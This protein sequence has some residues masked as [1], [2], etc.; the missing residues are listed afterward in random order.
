MAYTKLRDLIQ[1]AQDLQATS[2]GLTYEEM[3]EKLG[4]RGHTP[5]RKT[6]KRMMDGL[7]ELRCNFQSLFDNFLKLFELDL[8]LLVHRNVFFQS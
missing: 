7:Y 4:E 6:V 5:S 8:D 2:I 3:I 1:L